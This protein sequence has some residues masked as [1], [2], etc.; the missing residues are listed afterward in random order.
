MTAVHENS[1]GPRVQATREAQRRAI[2]ITAGIFATQT[3]EGLRAL[4]GERGET[5]TTPAEGLATM[6]GQVAHNAYQRFLSITER[7]EA[8]G[9][10]VDRAIRGG[11][12]AS[13]IPDHDAWCEMAVRPAH[14]EPQFGVA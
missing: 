2:E 14:Y 11:V 4:L 1:T 5:W 3:V 9:L 12:L 13:D 8:L 7:A 10:D 6:A